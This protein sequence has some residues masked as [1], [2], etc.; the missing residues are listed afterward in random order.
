MQV[1]KQTRRR[2]NLNTTALGHLDCKL[3]ADALDTI[4]QV[5][6][7]MDGDAVWLGESH[8]FQEAARIADEQGDGKAWVGAADRVDDAGDVGSREDIEILR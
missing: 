7:G 6:G 5:D 1:Q 2:S 3:W 8:A 4:L